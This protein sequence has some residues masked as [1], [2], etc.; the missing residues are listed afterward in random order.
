[1]TQMMQTGGLQRVFWWTA[2]G[3]LGLAIAYRFLSYFR[4]PVVL[5]AL[6]LI[7]VI[8]AGLWHFEKVYFPLLIV[9]FVWA[10]TNMPIAGAMGTAR[11]LVLGVGAIA[12]TFLWLREKHQSFTALHLAAF[13]VV[14]EALVSAI[15]SSDPYG[16]LLKVSSL[17]LLFLYGSTGARLVIAGREQIFL[18]EVLRGCQII[19]FLSAF[20]YAIGWMVWGNPN[21]LGAVIGIAVMPIVLWG[22]LIAETS[23]QK[24]WSLVAILICIA[25]LYL[26]LSR[27]SILAACVSTTVLLICLRRQ[28]LLLKGA[29]LL[30][31]LLG[32]GGVLEPSRIE[33]FTSTLTDTLLYKGKQD[34]GVLGSRE[35]PWNDTV[36][37]LKQHPWFGSGWGTSDIGRKAKFAQISL[38]GGI[39]S[40]DENREHG[41]SYLA[42]AEY[43]G[44]IGIVPFAFL[45]FLVL[46]MIFQICL[47]MRRTSNPHHPAIPLAMM[48]CAGLVH[49]FFEDWM[50]APGSYL[51]VFFWAG[52]FLLNDLMPE[53]QSLRLKAPSP[54][55][56]RVAADMLVSTR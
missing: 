33:S 23:Y 50:S 28:R 21:S 38:L 47:W 34:E 54:A 3:L 36:A 14:A 16:S 46:R 4:S 26:S 56:P 44:F 13:F 5:G 9:V 19:V 30:A 49:A 41:S 35:S 52:V 11:W 40:A 6:I 25:L 29:L 15:V 10:G 27:A 45:F 12:G 37:S 18:R 20:A 32:I 31:I 17:F 51:C 39:S 42:I 55:H 24:C 7:E 22:F 8:L 43:V 48:L 2:A 53:H 1:M